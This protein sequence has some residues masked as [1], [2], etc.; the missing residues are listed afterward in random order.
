[1]AV[2]KGKKT[3]V[4]PEKVETLAQLVK[5][6]KSKKTILIASI[7]NVPLSQYQEITKKLRGKA[8]VKVPRKSLITRTLDSLGDEN[9]QKL[10]TRIEPSTAL[11]FSDLDAFD[12]ALELVNKRSPAKAKAGQEA[13]MD[14]EIPAGPTE[15]IP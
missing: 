15:L 12:L 10:K 14:I 11:F 2:K 4:S 13:P 6:A 1:M 9:V 3:H 7:K 5:L 8:V